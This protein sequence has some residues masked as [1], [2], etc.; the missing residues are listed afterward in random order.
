[1]LHNYI[2]C[3]KK[4]K[5]SHEIEEGNLISPKF[6]NDGLIPVITMCSKTKEILM[7]GY[8]NVEALKKQLKRKK[9]IILVDQEKQF[10]I[11][12]KQVDL[13]KK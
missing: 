7:H 5:M 6:D 9:L 4:E 13:L 10:G 2:I 11:K 1:M 8:M 12:E 3:S